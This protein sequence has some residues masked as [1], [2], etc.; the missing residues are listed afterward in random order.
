MIDDA[1]KK[2]LAHLQK[3]ANLALED[4]GHKIGLSRNAVWRRIRRLD[5]TGVIQ[6]RVALIEPEA[7]NL[8]LSVFILIRTN[9]HNA[10]W[11]DRFSKAIDALPE[12]VGAYRTSGDIDYILHAR[13]PNMQEYDAL[14]RR[15]VERVELSD[16]SGSFVMEE[17]KQVTELPLHFA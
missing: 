15:L 1:D 11:L 6:K 7:V 13:I 9:Q 10:D 2:I 3:D 4:I 5:E 14:Y 12:I 16:V 8:G 17:I